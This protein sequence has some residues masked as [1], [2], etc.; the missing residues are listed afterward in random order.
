MTIGQAEIRSAV[1]RYLGQ[2]PGERERLARL[3]D[4]LD[5]GAAITSRSE[6]RGH[7]T[8][9]VI[10]LDPAGRVMHI[11]HNALRR[12][13]PPGGHLEPEDGSLPEAALRELAE[14][15]GVGAS[16]VFAIPGAG[17]GPIDIGVHRI[18]ASE[19]RNEAAHWHFDFRYVFGAESDVAVQLQETEVAGFRWF[20]TGDMPPGTLR[21]KVE[22]VCASLP[23]ARRS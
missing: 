15:T 12:W 23:Q 17:P 8:C 22:R 11:R 5:A 9:G 1:E 6:F 18:P 19:A 21:D 7:V 13:L 3:I 10:L 20:T 14:E 2:H 16:A 4:S